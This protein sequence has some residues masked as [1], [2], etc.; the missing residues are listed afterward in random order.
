VCSGHSR[1]STLVH[2]RGS[3]APSALTLDRVLD[4]GHAA[5]CCT[6]I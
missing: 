3:I 2:R 6:M 5:G 1:D 4:A